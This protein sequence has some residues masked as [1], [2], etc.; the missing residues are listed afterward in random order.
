LRY[1]RKI[2]FQ[3][4]TIKVMSWNVLY[5]EYNIFVLKITQ[6]STKKS[7]KCIYCLFLVS[8]S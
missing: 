2:P 5:G 7:N 1:G 4:K 3:G 8:T 6:I